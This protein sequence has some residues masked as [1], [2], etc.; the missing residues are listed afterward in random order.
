[1]SAPAQVLAWFRQIDRDGS[2]TLDVF[3]LQRALALGQLNFSLKTVQALMRLHDK[4]AS[5]H[6]DLQEF[7][8][9]HSFLINISNSFRYFDADRSG[10]LSKQEVWQALHHAGFRLDP[11]AFEALFKA[12]DPDRSGTLEM[13]E[14]VAMS[15]FLQSASA[16]F[17]AFDSQQTGRITMDFSQ[18]VYACSNVS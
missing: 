8:R 9:L 11:P 12:Y 16:T 14:F 6:I 3:E 5:G 7:E 13:A 2:G 10:S 1:M 18:F 15:V 17:R 4:D